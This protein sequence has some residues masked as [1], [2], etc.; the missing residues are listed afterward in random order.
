MQQTA[1]NAPSTI[2]VS[3]MT[4]TALMTAILCILCPFSVPIGPIPVTLGVFVVYLAAY[5]LGPWRA[6]LAS[7]LYLLLGAIG[8]P[9]FSGYA[10]GIGKLLGPTGGYLV[11]YLPLA[12]IAGFFIL[13]AERITELSGEKSSQTALIAGISLQLAGL[14]LGLFVCYLLGTVWFTMYK[15]ADGMTFAQALGICV[16]PFLPFDAGKIVVALLA[17]NAIRTALKKAHL[18]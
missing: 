4:L 7:A 12:L 2:S 10:G 11:G 3:D 13:R 9:V 8:L 18:V 1:V 17:G 6:A 14:I 15:S 16:V 5:T